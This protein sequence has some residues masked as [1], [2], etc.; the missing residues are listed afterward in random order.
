MK[1]PQNTLKQNN[2]Y[3]LE[4]TISDIKHLIAHKAYIVVPGNV[5]M[6]LEVFLITFC[7]IRLHFLS[8]YPITLLEFFNF[9]G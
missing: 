2:C 9:A 7:K 1:D 4:N 6:V 5:N 8:S 3:M